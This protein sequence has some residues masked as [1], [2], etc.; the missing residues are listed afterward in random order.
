METTLVHELDFNP[1]TQSMNKRIYFK[2]PKK[3]DWF[4]QTH[5]EFTYDQKKQ[6]KLQW[7]LSQRLKN[8]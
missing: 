1:R 5:K 8:N 4:K 3:V 6:A 2:N 7:K